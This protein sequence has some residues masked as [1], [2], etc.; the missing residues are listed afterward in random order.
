MS[1]PYDPGRPED[2]PP[3]QPAFGSPGFGTLPGARPSRTAPVDVV[4]AAQLMFARVAV[5]VVGALLTL[6]SANAI[7][8]AIR[9]ANPSFSSDKVDSRYNAIVVTSIALSVVIAVLYILLALQVRKGKNWARI[10]TWVLSGL[11]VLFGLAG[12]LGTGT[13][14]EK[15]V[16]VVGLLIDVAIIVLLARKPSNEYFA[17]MKGPRY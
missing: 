11:S 10:T 13:G 14:L 8:D 16:F 5:G 6:S 3:D 4:R 2:R 12:L 17:A 1:T 9:E 7:K 15:A